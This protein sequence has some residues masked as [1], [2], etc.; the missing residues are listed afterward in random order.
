MRAIGV[1]VVTFASSVALAQ[2]KK[3]P[4]PRPVPKPQPHVGL[5]QAAR[6]A[7]ASGFVDDPIAADAKRIAYVVADTAGTAAVHVVDLAT[8]AETATFDLAPV[9]LKPRSIDWVG[10]R[11]FV[12]TDADAEGTFQIG[13]LVDLKGKVI[14]KT[15]RATN[16]QIVAPGGKPR[17]A[18]YRSE[19]RKAGGSRNVVELRDPASGKRV[20]KV[21]ALELDDTGKNAK[22]DFTVNHWAHGFTRAIGRKGGTWNKK[23]D[24]RSPDVEAVYDI[25]AGKFIATSP[26]ADVVAQRKRFAILKDAGGKD[27]FVRW[28]PDLA[29]LELWIDGAKTVVVVDQPQ[30]Q[31]DHKSLDV[32]FAEATPWIGLQVDPVNAE[33]VARKKADP[34][35]WDLFE[36]LAGGKAARRGRL[37]AYG[38]RLRFGWAGDKLWV[39]ERNIGFD[40]GGKALV[41]Y[42]RVAP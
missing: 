10:D 18:L 9:T 27:R 32:A 17:V 42:N 37:Y 2:P 33:A 25:V 5:V 36:V 34:E 28:S 40:R 38:Q 13:A 39:L 8:G 21:K 12:V 1:L 23:D 14:Y 15:P 7:P 4:P 35:F 31:Y 6:F 41:V 19:A 16:V 30:L 3:D 20:G 26:I 11:L 22:L 29:D 24:Q